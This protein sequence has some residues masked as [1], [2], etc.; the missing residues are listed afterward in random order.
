MALKSELASP[1]YDDHVAA[2]LHFNGTQL[3]E[4]GTEDHIATG[5]TIDALI[6]ALLQIG[7]SEEWDSAASLGTSSFYTE[8]AGSE[9]AIDDK[10]MVCGVGEEEEEKNRS[11]GAAGEEPDARRAWEDMKKR[12][13]HIEESDA[14]P[15]DGAGDTEGDSREFRARRRRSWEG[16]DDSGE[17]AGRCEPESCREEAAATCWLLGSRGWCF[18]ATGEFHLHFFPLLQFIDSLAFYPLFTVRNV[19]M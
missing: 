13:M 16:K 18:H 8:N 3:R 17:W 10:S 4:Q 2:P 9:N 1:L 11:V 15:L 5:Y 19:R 12:V 14:P 7:D 6:D